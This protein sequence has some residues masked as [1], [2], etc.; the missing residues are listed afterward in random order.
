MRFFIFLDRMFDNVRWNEMKITGRILK[1]S[2]MLAFLRSM[3]SCQ[4]SKIDEK[5]FHKFTG[6]SQS[7]CFYVAQSIILPRAE[8]LVITVIF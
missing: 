1:L 7:P 2:D 5:V 6:C 4:R 8:D 3:D